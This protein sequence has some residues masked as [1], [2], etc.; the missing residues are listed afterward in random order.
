MQ[1]SEYSEYSGPRTFAGRHRE[2]AE[3]EELLRHTRL[4]TLTGPGGVGKSAL[5]G[6][7]ARRSALAPE[8]VVGRT[9]LASLGDP[10]LVPHRL[11]RALR[12]DGCPGKP[13]LTALAEALGDCPALLVV[14][15]CEHLAAP[16]TEVFT[17]LVDACPGL[18]ILAT[19]R[20]P[21]KTPG[22]YALPPLPPEEAAGLFEAHAR[23][24]GAEP[25]PDTVRR[26]CAL[27]EGLP[28]AVLIA[29]DQLGHHSADDVLSRLARPEDA[30]DLPASAPGLPGRHRTL[31]DSLGWSR[32]LCTAQ[33]QLLWARCSVFPGGFELSHVLEV[34][35][36]HR[37][38]PGP[39]AAAF[40]GLTWQSLIEP[41]PDDAETTVFR[42]RRVTRAYGRQQLA[43][44]D[45]ERAVTNR[46]LAW[47]VNHS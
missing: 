36:D 40:T 45:E 13:Q 15:T 12:L 1:E 47:A 27:V 44:S 2:L 14:D 10:G 22:L 30:L 9:D 6:A 17:E 42:M 33:E 28:L 5:A 43:R 20:T 11:A 4:V 19:S 39:L 16:G 31:R 21:L 41:V 25:A 23:R 38:P 32:R 8:A 46:F 7:V 26:I 18:H 29:A 37:L 34:C 24:L 35:G 3:V